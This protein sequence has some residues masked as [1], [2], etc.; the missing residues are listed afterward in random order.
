MNSISCVT[1]GPWG[2]QSELY[3]ADFLDECGGV[4]YANQVPPN[5]GED[6][7]RHHTFTTITP[8]L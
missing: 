8:S 2:D 7:S 4:F 1:W 5:F 6:V 3:D